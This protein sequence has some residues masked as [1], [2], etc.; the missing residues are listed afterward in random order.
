MIQVVNSASTMRSEYDYDS[1][2]K[3]VWERR[4]GNG[5]GEWIYFFGADGQRM[6]RYALTVGASTISFSQNQASVWFGRKLAQKVDTSGTRSWPF[7]DRMASV[8]KYLPYG[9]DKPGASNPANDNEKFATYTRDG[10]SGIDY[11]DRRWYPSGSGR[12]ITADPLYG[13]EEPARPQSWN[14]YSYVYGNPVGYVD[15]SGEKPCPVGSWDSC[16]EVVS[17]AVLIPYIQQSVG[18]Y[19]LQLEAQDTEGRRYQNRYRRARQWRAAASDPN[20]PDYV[21]D[22]EAL[23]NFAS[24]VAAD[25]IAQGDITSGSF[26]ESFGVLVSEEHPIVGIVSILGMPIDSTPIGAYTEIGNHGLP[27]GYQT[28]Y[29]DN[30]AQQDQGHHFAAYFQ[31]GYLYGTSLSTLGAFA[32]DIANPGDIRLALAAISIGN[33]LSIGAITPLDVSHLIRML[34]DGQGQ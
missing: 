27:S 21:N 1:G 8:G 4:T 16:V 3:R 32:T 2:N 9:E 31:F 26:V 24:D 5:S 10:G 29:Q 12:F 11:A 6:G 33:S 22:C 28:Q 25:L 18:P 19:E 30:Q 20:R 17:N 7:A 34:C 13:S 23:A 15:V 14:R